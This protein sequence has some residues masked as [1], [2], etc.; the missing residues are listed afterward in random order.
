MCIVVVCPDLGGNVGRRVTA[1]KNRAKAQ[2]G[3][4]GLREAA[5]YL[6]HVGYTSATVAKWLSA[7]G[8][9]LEAEQ[10]AR[11]RIRTEL[12]S[13]IRLFISSF[14]STRTLPCCRA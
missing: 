1:P 8:T 9:V 14:P 4:M 6:D 7:V 3:V 11:H 5:M 13:K 12:T 10:Q 2:E